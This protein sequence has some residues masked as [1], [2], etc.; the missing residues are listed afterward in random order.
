MPTKFNQELYAKIKAK[1]NEPLSSIGL[2]RLR[3]VEKEKE[4]EVMEKGS[5]TPTLDEGRAAFPSVSIEEMVPRGK[6]RKTGDKGKEKV[7]ASIWAD[8]GTAM[9]LANEIVTLED[10]KEISTVPSH[11][12]VNRHVH[13]LVQ[14]FYHFFSFYFIFL[15]SLVNLD[16]L[17]D[18][19]C[20]VLGETMH[21]T[22]QCLMSKEK[23]MVATSKAEALEEEASG[24]RKDLI[25]AMDANNSSKENILALTEQLN[26]KKLL[27]K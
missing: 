4:K 15:L 23:A 16:S 8:V 9:A 11:E 2:R 22:S 1:K 18:C 17:C 12:M 13:K 10:L 19:G 24:L 14:V 7:R 26:A 27:V 25:E 5:S 20:Q 3:V 21:I 6:K